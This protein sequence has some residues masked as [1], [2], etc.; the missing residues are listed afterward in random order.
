MYPVSCGHDC[1]VGGLGNLLAV[2]C[3][4]VLPR[5]YE[6]AERR[7]CA[8]RLFLR[9]RDVR[10]VLRRLQLERRVRGVRGQRVPRGGALCA[11][12]LLGGR[13]DERVVLAVPGGRVPKCVRC[14]QRHV[15]GPLPRGLLLWAA[16]DERDGGHV[17]ARRVGGARRRRR[18][19][20]GTL[21]RGLLVRRRVR[22]RDGECVRPG[23]LLPAR[24]EPPDALR[25][26]A[27][28]P[29]AQ[30][31]RGV[32]RRALPRGLFLPAR[33]SRSQTLRARHPLRRQ[34]DGR[35]DNLPRWPL[36][37][38]RDGAAALH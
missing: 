19:V 35:R 13:G 23:L 5:Q 17:S 15:H 30:Q 29:G 24:L 11:G 33:Y 10:V 20:H 18:C 14:A 32:V 25:R 3:G 1:R 16:V 6:R 28:W 31:H 4:R 37:Q 2:P 7:M 21:R 36:L 27:L 34:H 38:Q 8:W 22:Q 26:G 9:R 12:L